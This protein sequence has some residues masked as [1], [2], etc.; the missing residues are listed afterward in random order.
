MPL[1]SPTSAW[2]AVRFLLKTAEYAVPAGLAWMESLAEDS[3]E[4]A[5]LAWVR[6]VLVYQRESPAGTSEDIAQFKLD[7]LNITGGAV[8][9]SWTDG[10][11]T[12][13]KA[14]LNT[15]ATALA[16]EISTV[17]DHKET[18]YYAMA[19]NPLPDIVKPFAETGPPF[20]VDTTA[21][22]SSGA[23]VMPYQVATT[24]TFRTAWP[25]HWGRAYVPSPW[26][27]AGLLTAQGRLVPAHQTAVANA[28]RA[29]LNGLAD[30][31]FL[32]VVPVG[33]VD[34]QPFHALLGVQAVV[35]DD[36]PDVQRRR[37]PKIAAARTVA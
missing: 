20:A 33:Q 6:A 25:R 9:T 29:A 27:S 17:V 12:A 34:K 31:G 26:H 15:L 18:R 2:K 30:D 11:V 28:F 4:V 5:E 14:R 1:P 37:R 10:D 19:F 8:D 3:A 22:A 36:V 7:L 23:G 16:P 32:A 35:V 21:H 24:A 13:V